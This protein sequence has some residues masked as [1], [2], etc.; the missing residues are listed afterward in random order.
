MFE[1]C[2]KQFDRSHPVSRTRRIRCTYC[3]LRFI[4]PV[5][6]IFIITAWDGTLNQS[7]QSTEISGNRS[8]AL[9]Y[10]DDICRWTSSLEERSLPFYIF[11]PS[12]T[13]AERENRISPDINRRNGA[14]EARRDISNRWG[15]SPASANS[16][17][18]E[19]RRRGRMAPPGGRTPGGRI[20]AHSRSC[21]TPRRLGASILF[22][23]SSGTGRRGTGLPDSPGASRI[24]PPKIY[25]RN[26]T[27]AGPPPSFLVSSFA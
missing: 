10:P 15:R 19:S 23:F 9:S 21:G 16:R 13:R 24:S 3:E 1:A 22:R 27:T 25:F 20:S 4:L 26:A 5:H 11:R 8:V 12:E 7:F 18:I 14:K 17:P 2:K 6:L